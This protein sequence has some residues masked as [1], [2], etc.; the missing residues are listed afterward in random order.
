MDSANRIFAKEGVVLQG[1]HEH[2]ERP[3]C[4]LR[5]WD[6]RDNRLK[7]R[8][9]TG[10]LASIT[11]Q[12]RP[13]FAFACYS[14][15]HRVFELRLVGGKLEEEIGQLVLHLSNA[16]RRLIDLVDNHDRC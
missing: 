7:D 14:V 8:C 16:P 5:R 3:I 11:W 6:M 1:R 12:C 15:V 2:L 10:W 4:H 13:G 9:Q